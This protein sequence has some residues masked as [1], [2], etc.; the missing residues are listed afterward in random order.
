MRRTP[1]SWWYTPEARAPARLLD[2]SGGVLKPRLVEIDQRHIGT[3]VGHRGR[4][5]LADALR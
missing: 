2:Q 5:G 1:P 4:D 3:G